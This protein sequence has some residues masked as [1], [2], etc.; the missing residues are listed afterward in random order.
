M[1][2][3]AEGA[4]E[5]LVPRIGSSSIVWKHFAFQASD[6]KQEYA[7]SAIKLFWHHKATQ[8]TSLTTLKN[9]IKFNTMNV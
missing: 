8:R 3:V 7:K 1:S 2:N 4:A 9:T 5:G 6:T